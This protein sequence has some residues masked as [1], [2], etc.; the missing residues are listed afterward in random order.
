MPEVLLSM[1]R[2]TFRT[3]KRQECFPS[4]SYLARELPT[5]EIDAHCQ[6]IDAAAHAVREWRKDL[7]DPETGPIGLMADLQRHF[8]RTPKRS[9][10]MKVLYLLVGVTGFEPATSTSQT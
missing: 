6:A 4:G 10:A 9:K 5:W 3:G 2:L 1:G 7:R 8:R